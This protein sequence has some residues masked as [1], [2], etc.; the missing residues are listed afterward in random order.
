MFCAEPEL[1]GQKTVLVWR[2]QAG[3][4]L[5]AQVVQLLLVQLARQV[6]VV[7][8]R[9]EPPVQAVQRQ[10]EQREPP[11]RVVQRQQEQREPPVRVV[12]LRQQEQREPPVQAVQRQQEQREPPVPVQPV[13]VQPVLLL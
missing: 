9:Q 3:P 12:V 11:V 13:P 8:L 6:R 4:E 2:G 7:V 1:C 5:Q 10:R